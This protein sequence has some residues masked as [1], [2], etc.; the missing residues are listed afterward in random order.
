MRVRSEV[1]ADISQN[2]KRKAFALVLLILWVAACRP[3][4]EAVP[5]FSPATPPML[6]PGW[7]SYTNANDILD[8][9]LDRQGNIWTAGSGGVAKWDRESGAYTKYTAEHGLPGNNVR[10]LVQ[11]S[12][13]AIWFA[14][15]SGVARFDGR[16]WKAFTPTAYTSKFFTFA[17][18]V[19]INLLLGA[20]SFPI[21]TENDS[22]AS[23]M[24]S[25]VTW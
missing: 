15:R 25:I 7:T 17:A 14:T 21:S 3:G 18:C 1:D 10:A 4:E 20:T 9:L 13:G 19:W 24:S 23:T 6:H 5:T 22:S 12:D 16:D 11:A 2:R 8:V